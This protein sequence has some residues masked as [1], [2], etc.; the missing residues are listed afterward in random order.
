MTEVIT[1]TC[2]RCGASNFGTRY[3]ENCGLDRQAPFDA[4]GAASTKTTVILLR[5]ATML[6][7]ILITVLPD[8]L[9]LVAN[10]LGAYGFASIGSRVL[11]VLLVLATAAAASVAARIAGAPGGARLAAILIAS[12][13]GGLAAIAAI[14]SPE[15]VTVDGLFAACLFVSWGLSARFRGYGYFGLLVGLVLS[16]VLSIIEIPLAFTTFGGEG[17]LGYDILGG[18]LEIVAFA[19]AIGSAVWFERIHSRRPIVVRPPVAMNA[20]PAPM[21]NAGAQGQ[22]MAGYGPGMYYG[23]RT[24]GFAVASMIL[25]LLGLSLFAIIFGHVALGQIRRSGERGGG[26]AVTGLVFG[27]LWL[28]GASIYLIVLYAALSQL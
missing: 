3:C 11:A 22:P 17:S 12:V 21:A 5:I 10:S 25:G 26:M 19:T 27:Y 15:F 6:G 8:V 23:Q 7:L 28:V 13:G 16:Y 9:S 4:G 14:A 24:N 2:V 20:Y 1:G 18:V